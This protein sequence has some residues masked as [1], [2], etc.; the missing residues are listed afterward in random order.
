MLRA[1]YEEA[2]IL[3]RREP[4]E[5]VLAAPDLDAETRRKLETVLAARAFA[6]GLGFDVDGSFG[7][8]SYSDEGTNVIVVTGAKRTALEPYTWWFPVVGRVPYKGYFDAGRAKAEAASLE[9]RGYDTYV[10]A[11]P[12]F[13]TLG[14]FADPLLRHQLRHDEEFLVDLVLHELYHATYY[15]NGQSAF[16]ESLATFAGHRGAIA[17]FRAHPERAHASGGDDLLAQAEAS[18]DDA[19]RFGTFV[20]K[21]AMSLRATYAANP[22]PAAAVV[23]RDAVFA[24]ARVEYAGLPFV[25]GGFPSFAKEPLNNAVLLHYLLYG[26]DLEIFEAIYRNQGEDLRRALTFIHDAAETAPREPF[27]AVR[28]AFTAAA[29]P[30]SAAPI[31]APPP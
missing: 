24:A 11:A 5:Q 29:P 1:G 10:R 28:R 15:V 7:S 4:M 6:A 14:W 3:W 17:F 9:A 31:A 16:N 18:W 19:L 13:S 30:G 21:L 12:A 23:A 2:K 25:A 8:L 26:T 20:E 27:A 22:D